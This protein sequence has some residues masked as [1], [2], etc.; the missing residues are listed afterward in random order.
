MLPLAF[1]FCETIWIEHNSSKFYSMNRNISW[2]LVHENKLVELEGKPCIFSINNQIFKEFYKLFG[3]HLDFLSKKE[4]YCNNLFLH[5]GVHWEQQLTIASF[6]AGAAALY[7][8][9]QTAC[10][11]YF[12][13]KILQV[14]AESKSFEEFL[15]HSLWQFGPLFVRSKWNMS[16]ILAN[17]I[18]IPF[19]LGKWRSNGSH[20][21][22]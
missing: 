15:T 11:Q 19:W 1:L 18:H 14:N 12:C 7:N 3:C 16:E 17:F 2:K 5:F 20:V 9:F 13:E 4:L 22:C 8:F 21:R 10:M 6:S